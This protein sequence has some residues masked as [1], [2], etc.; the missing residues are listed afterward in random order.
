MTAFSAHSIF[1]A[2]VLS[3][4]LAAPAY[5]QDNTAAPAT[6]APAATTPSDSATSETPKPEIIETPQAARA[7]ISFDPEAATEAYLATIKGEARAK[8]DAY[9]EGGYVLQAVDTAYAL[10][11]AGILLWGRFSA[12][13]RN[14]AQR[15]TRM[16]W[17]QV[18]IYAVMYFLVAA[19]LTFP[20]TVYEQF[21]REHQYGLSNQDFM[22]W[23]T[24]FIKIFGVNILLVTVLVTIIYAFIR[25]T[26]ERWWLWATAISVLFVAFTAM[27]FPVYVAPLINDY[28]PLAEGTIKQDIL[29]MARANGVPADNVWE[30]NASKQSKRISANVSGLLDTTRIS[31]NDNLLKRATPPEIRAVMGHELGHYVL[32]HVYIFLSWFLIIIFIFLGFANWA[33][34]RLTAKF[35]N[36]WD[37]HTIDD[38]AGMPLIFALISFLAFVSTP[39]LNTM[40]RT[41]EAQADIFGL[42]AAREPDGF[43]TVSLKLSEYRKLDPTPL[44]EFV[45]YDH[46]SGRSRISMAMHWKAEHLNEQAGR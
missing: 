24:D 46:P 37:V 13:M 16:R 32:D 43:A 5:A 45:Y 28:K 15:L 31:L 42:N 41:I 22:G 44:E 1:L 4:A 27:I 18:P 9:F 2:A 23:F 29:S 17:L 7:Q 12:R 25:A 40:T 34:K 6:E 8:S 30:F 14:L 33:F 10:I 21:Y 3:L 26:R 39:V 35:G 20:L 11:V 36:S 38:P 19:L